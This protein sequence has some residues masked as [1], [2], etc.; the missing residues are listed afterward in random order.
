MAFLKTL[1]L[2]K[3]RQILKAAEPE[4]TTIAKVANSC[5]FWS[6]NHFSRDYKTMFGETPTA[7]LKRLR[8]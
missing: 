7:T 5:G 2:Q 1:R 6:L 4:A 3:V 8:A